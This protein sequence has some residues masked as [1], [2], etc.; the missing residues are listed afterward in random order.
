MVS[1]TGSPCNYSYPTDLCGRR[2]AKKIY[3]IP[4]KYTDC[5]TRPGPL[6]TTHK[7]I[8]N[9]DMDE[10]YEVADEA[11][12]G[13]ANGNRPADVQV[14]F[15]CGLCAPCQELVSITDE[16]LG[17]LNEFPDLVGHVG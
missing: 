14:F 5:N 4:R 7:D 12:D 17:D 11:H 15:L 9:W 8:V 10:F 1:K 2:R 16:L 6:G 13:E 3:K